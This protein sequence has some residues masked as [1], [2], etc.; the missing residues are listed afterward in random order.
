M[1]VGV[2]VKVGG[3]D[4]AVNVG[5]RVGVFAVV[6]EAAAALVPGVGDGRMAEQAER[7]NTSTNVWQIL[8]IH[9][10]AAVIL[11]RTP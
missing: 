2:R 8:F 9:N 6:G 4:M 5:V 3:P 1:R 7:N 11:L 10:L